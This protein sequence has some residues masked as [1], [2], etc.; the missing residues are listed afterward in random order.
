MCKEFGRSGR[1]VTY[2]AAIRNAVETA[3]GQEPELRD[4]V[5]PEE[6]GSL[7]TKGTSGGT[8]IAAQ[9]KGGSSH[10]PWGPQTV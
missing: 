5:M 2:N 7:A 4:G 6:R 8:L 3:T 1:V 9:K 10:G